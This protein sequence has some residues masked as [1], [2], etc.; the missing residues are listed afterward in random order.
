M[1]CL[2]PLEELILHGGFWDYEIKVTAKYVYEFKLLNSD[3]IFSFWIAVILIHSLLRANY[4]HLLR[5]FIL[6]KV[7]LKMLA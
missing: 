3:L 5:Y 1:G 4:F 2:I 7:N 6:T